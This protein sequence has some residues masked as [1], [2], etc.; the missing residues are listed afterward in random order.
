MRRIALA[1]LLGMLFQA[2]CVTRQRI[3]VHTVPEGAQI[4]LIKR[5]I[6]RVSG[7]VAGVGYAGAQAERFEDPPILLGPSP[8]SYEFRIEE[9][10]RT[11]YTGGVSASSTKVVKEVV[12]DAS[13]GTLHARRR[14]AITGEPLRVELTL[15]P[16]EASPPPGQPGPGQI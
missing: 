5:G 7:A 4:T 16:E 2:G 6:R 8:V 13:R 3:V 9:P 10:E 1:A 11:F 14:F 15:K 12:I